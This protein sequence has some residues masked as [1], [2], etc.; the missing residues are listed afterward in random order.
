VA[1]RSASPDN[2]ALVDGTSGELLGTIE[3]VRAY[4]TVHEGA[5]YLHLG[6]SYLVLELDL[7]TRRAILE[8]FS[9]NYFTQTKSEIMTFIER[10]H[11]SRE[12]HGVQLFY[13]DIIY[14][15]TVL[16]YQRKGL[17]DHSVIDFQGLEMPTTEFATRALWYELDELV[18]SPGAQRSALSRN[19]QPGSAGSPASRPAE[20]FPA[21]QLLGALHALEHGQIAVL[22]LIA[23][24]DRWD[25][26]GLSTNAH[27]Q[28]GGPTIFIYDGHPG[29]IGITRRG[30]EQFD[31]LVLDAQRLIGEC[32]CDDGCP[33]CVQSPKCGNLNE[34]LSKRGALELLHRMGAAC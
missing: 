33:S 12:S 9:G 4:S 26:G 24:C 7:A 10:A 1:L 19:R 16:G 21:D 25:I 23:M 22:P 6:R 20:A 17:Q 28:T 13:G 14:S 3:A 5:I 31:R 11:T 30:Y 15:E 2:F 29:G 8:P 32:R 18:G 34:P 27:P